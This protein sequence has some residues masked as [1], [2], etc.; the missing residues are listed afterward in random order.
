MPAYDNDRYAP[1]APIARVSLQHPDSGESVAD[2]PMLLD[3]GADATLLPKS[4]V[5]ALGLAGT[6]EW[7]E[8]VAFDGT[9][10]ESEA[11]Q[12][13]LVFLNKTFR[14]RV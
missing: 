6:G 8:L 10:D 1:P 5:R 2:I 9:T 7:Y 12:A 13:V 3:T 14:G 11:V 4:A